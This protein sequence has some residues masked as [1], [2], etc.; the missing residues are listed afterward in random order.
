[1]NYPEG[2]KLKRIHNWLHKHCGY[3]KYVIDCR[4]HPCL[5]TFLDRDHH[6]IEGFSLIDES[7][8]SCSLM[9][10]G[11]EPVNKQKA[12]E[13]SAFYKKAGRYEYLIKYFTPEDGRGE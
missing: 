6:D 11:I 10:C 8:M 4:D 1:M 7:G 12:E 3:G 13:M 9:H 5:V 2:R